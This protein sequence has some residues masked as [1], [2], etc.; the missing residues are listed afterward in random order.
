MFSIGDKIV[1]PLHGAGVIEEIRE[2]EILGNLRTYYV[3]HVGKGMTVMIPA[4]DT[5]SL[6]VRTICSAEYA[7][8][9]LSC[10]GQADLEYNNNW[11]RRY[12]ENID[13]LRG[14][15]MEDTALIIK[16]L[17]DR[18]RKKGLSTGEKKMLT[19]ATQ[20]LVSELA[21]AKEI[22]YEEAEQLLLDALE[23]ALEAE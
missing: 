18:Q 14:G 8:Q 23:K 21:L 17:Y 16:S 13:R 1:Y 15:K 19:S 22:A 10:I 11:N 2:M 3:M 9:A 6:G 5:A 7:M 20:I 4:E 12:R